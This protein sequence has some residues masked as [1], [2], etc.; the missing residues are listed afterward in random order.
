MVKTALTDALPRNSVWISDAQR[1]APRAEIRQ[2]LVT[3]LMR[4]GDAFSLLPAAAFAA[5]LP[6][7]WIVLVAAIVVGI[8]IAHFK[9]AAIKDWISRCKFSKGEHYRSLDVGLK[10]FNSAIGG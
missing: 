6:P 5:W 10:A 3:A 1:Q 9:A 4:S 8:V 2:R 7:L